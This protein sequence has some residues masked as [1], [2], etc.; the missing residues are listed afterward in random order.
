MSG[1]LFPLSSTLELE[2]C[3]IVWMRDLAAASAG[4]LIAVD[5]KTTRRSL[6]TANGKAEIGW[7]AERDKWTGREA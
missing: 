2:R 7:F 4:C 3:F 6:D 1:T 5:G